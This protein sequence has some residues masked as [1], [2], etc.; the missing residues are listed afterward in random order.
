[1]HTLELSSKPQKNIHYNGK[2]LIPKLENVT[3]ASVH[4][5]AHPIIVKEVLLKMKRRKNKGKNSKNRLGTHAAIFFE[6]LA[7]R[8]FY[9]KIG[10]ALRR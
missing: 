1:M 9:A 10:L 6:W 5:C 8:A 3:L 2:S 4:A 7:A